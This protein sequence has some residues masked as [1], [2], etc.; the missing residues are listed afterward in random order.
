MGEKIKKKILY[1][2]RRDRASNGRSLS[3]DFLLA[4]HIQHFLY[5]LVRSL[6][7]PTSFERSVF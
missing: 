4:K 6:V 3:Y 7:I 1:G 5:A 2:R